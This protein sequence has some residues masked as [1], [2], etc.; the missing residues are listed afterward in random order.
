M[1]T[2]KNLN[3]GTIAHVTSLINDSEIKIGAIY[4]EGG[5]VFAATMKAPENVNCT[6]EITIVICEYSGCLNFK[7]AIN[8]T[9]KLPFQL[10]EGAKKVWA[11]FVLD[12]SDELLEFIKNE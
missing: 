2:T 1:K 3:F 9:G 7:A 11:Q 5:S 10:T 8:K 6:S 4:A 12:V